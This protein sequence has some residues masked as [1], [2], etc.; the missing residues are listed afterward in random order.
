MAMTTYKPLPD[1]LT[2]STSMIEGLGLFATKDI[3]AGKVLGISH[4]K[5]DRFENNYIRTPLGGFY[6]HSSDP[7]CTHQI[8]EEF[9]RLVST[10]KINKGDEL[11][12]TYCLY[13]VKDGI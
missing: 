9:I 11:T 5:D 7:N 12:A 13:R 2:V 10:K 1:C 3:L 8:D 4:V 6:N